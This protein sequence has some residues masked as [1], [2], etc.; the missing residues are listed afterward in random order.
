M[1]GRAVAKVRLLSES[2][3]YSRTAFVQDFTVKGTRIFCKGDFLAVF[4][5]SSFKPLVI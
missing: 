2:G 1:C 3:F 5:F 4:K